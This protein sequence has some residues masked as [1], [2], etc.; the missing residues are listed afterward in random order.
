M[1]LSALETP[2]PVTRSVAWD[3]S[4]ATV[5]DALDRYLVAMADFYEVSGISALDQARFFNRTR[6][7]LSAVGG[8]GEGHSVRQTLT[9]SSNVLKRSDVDGLNLVINHAATV[10]D[11]DGR[12]GRAEPGAVQFRDMSRLSATRLDVV[13][14][15]SLM[16]PR[17]LAPP[18]LLGPKM[19][20]LILPPMT[21]GVRFIQLQM[22]TLAAEAEHMP[23][24][25]LDT[26][27]QALLL[28]VARTAGADMVIGAPETSALQGTVRRVAVDFIERQLNARNT[29][30]DVDSLAAMAGVS[31]ATLYRAFDGE[32][33]VNR[34]IQ[35]RR[36]HHAREA[37]RRRTGSKPTIADI[38][39]D[40]GFASQSHFSRLFRD[41]YGYPP[42]EVASVGTP[43]EIVLSE[44]PI[45]H[46]ILSAWIS[47][48]GKH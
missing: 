46:D 5:P 17:N 24:D 34:Y 14:L 8:I 37:I 25:V 20:G 19:H 16:V 7:T 38:A 23:G 12:D 9:R 39:W 42:S 44:G 2:P 13:D 32:G 28:V 6:S 45:R 3:V 31:R 43:V 33:G 47:E 27:I 30:T 4:T 11:Y 26:A 15:I 48:I 21:P 40:F 18:A 10:G 35:D 41:R 29:A 1:S 22:T 36:L